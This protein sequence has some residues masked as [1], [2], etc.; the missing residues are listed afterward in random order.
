[1]THVVGFTDAQDGSAV[2]GTFIPHAVIEASFA[3]NVVGFTVMSVPK[4]P[5]LPDA[6]E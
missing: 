6:P 1:M 5:F 2:V 3:D 4:V